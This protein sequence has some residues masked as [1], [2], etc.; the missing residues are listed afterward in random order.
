MQQNQ[1]NLDITKTSPILTK[2]GGKVWQQGFILRK[3]S[4]FLTGSSEDQIIP[5]PI[6]FDPVSGEI[7]KDGMPQQ[8]DF[9]F[10]DESEE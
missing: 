3:A 10:E 9:L 4:R 2:E 7:L 6:F 5:I 8:M 1:L